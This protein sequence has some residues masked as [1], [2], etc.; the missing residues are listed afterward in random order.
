MTL[1]NKIL[2]RKVFSWNN[3]TIEFLENGKMDAF[4]DGYYEFKDTYIIVTWF[5]NEECCI[6]FNNDYTHFTS[7]RKRDNDVVKGIYLNYLEEIKFITL[8]NSGYINYTLNCL[9]SL[10]QINSKIDLHCYCIGKEG[11]NILK[12]KGYTC[13]LIDEEQ[14]SNFQSFRTGNWSNITYNKFTIIHE[15]LLKY[16]Y[17][18]LT[19]GDIVYENPYFYNYL[20]KNIQDNDMLTQSDLDCNIPIQSELDCNIP[21]QS[22]SDC[23][24]PIQSELDCN[25]PIQ[26]DS[27]CNI[28][29]QSDF[30][31]DNEIPLCTGF[32]FIK[33]NPTTISLFD[34]KN[35]EQYKNIVGWDDQVYINDIKDKFKF[36]LLPLDL[37]PNGSYYYNNTNLNPYMIHFNW[38]VGHEKAEKIKFYNKWYIPEFPTVQTNT[39]SMNETE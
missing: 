32:M 17:V 6:V 4:G 31:N 20:L 1:F 26:S 23:N 19:D 25:I 15:N 8:T 37:F 14:N 12:D 35:V 22:D 24:I 38:L 9:E 27:D 2:E 39:V 13:S 10:K 5:G 18:C 11:C 33:S 16:K 3:Y 29:I 30:D 36:K 7:I 21:I 28:P 34:P